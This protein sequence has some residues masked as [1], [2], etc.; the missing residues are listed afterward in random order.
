MYVFI[1]QVTIS[2]QKLEP[3]QPTGLGYE[4]LCRIERADAKSPAF[5][6]RLPDAGARGCQVSNVTVRSDKFDGRL[7]CDASRVRSP[8]LG[9]GVL[10]RRAVRDET[11]ESS[12]SSSDSSDSTS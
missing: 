9:R 5:S 7:R 10:R 1:K 3:P 8:S 11:T 6:S 4:K 2:T 12:S